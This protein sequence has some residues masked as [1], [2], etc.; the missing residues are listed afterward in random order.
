MTIGAANALLKTLE[1]PPAHSLLLLI[2]S[3]PSALPATVR[4]RC[5]AIRFAPPAATQ[6]E[7]ALILAREIPPADARLLTTASQSRLGA[8]LTMDLADVRARQEELCGLVSPKTLRSVAAVLTA[9]EAL[10]KSDRGPEVL[11]WLAQWVRDLLLVRIG[12][13]QDYLI[14]VEQLAALQGAARGAAPDKL[15]GLLEEID[16]LQRSAGRHLNLQMALESVLLHLREA[17]GLS[18]GAAPAR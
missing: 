11:D 8:A 14:H 10:H 16:G 2:S 6:V 17:L 15:S 1:E 7:A 13:G 5:Q 3:R 4:S 18:A 9:A 12:V